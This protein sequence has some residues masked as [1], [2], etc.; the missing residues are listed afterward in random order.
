[1]PPSAYYSGNTTGTMPLMHPL[2]HLTILVTSADGDNT[3]HTHFISSHWYWEKK[4]SSRSQSSCHIRT[5][6]HQWPSAACA[7][8]AI[9]PVEFHLVGMSSIRRFKGRFYPAKH[10]LGRTTCKGYKFFWPASEVCNLRYQFHN[11]CTTK[12][13]T[14]VRQCIQWRI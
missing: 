4:P 2:S 10:W 3:E 6:S 11:C 1:M 12:L 14:C 9:W 7:A 8:T 13:R 5:G